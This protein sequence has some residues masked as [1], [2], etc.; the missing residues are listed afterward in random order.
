MRRR[1]KFLDFKVTNKEW[2]L[3]RPFLAIPADKEDK[4]AKALMR[5]S[6]NLYKAEWKIRLTN[7]HTR[8]KKSYYLQD[9]RRIYD[10][11]I[12]SWSPHEGL[13]SLMDLLPTVMAVSVLVGATA[14]INKDKEEVKE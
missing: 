8:E 5:W 1:Y 3:N 11:L 12:I 14:T 7:S 4:R 10:W 13:D 6:P 9:V 2:E